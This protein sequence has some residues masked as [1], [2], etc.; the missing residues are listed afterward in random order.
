MEAYR[1]RTVTVDEVN[2]MIQAVTRYL[3]GLIRGNDSRQ[4][5]DPVIDMLRAQRLESL[6]AT[7]AIRRE[8]LR[9]LESGNP[10]EAM[11]FPEDYEL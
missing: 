4:R 8:R 6:R 10:I 1:P 2:P 5:E 9:A 3:R 11:I 7:K